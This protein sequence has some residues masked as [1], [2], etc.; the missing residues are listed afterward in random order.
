MSWG[1]VALHGKLQQ[2]AVGQSAGIALGHAELNLQRAAL[3]QHRHGRLCGGK[4]THA[5]LA[6]TYHTREWSTQFRLCYLGL[7][8]VYLGTQGREVGFCLLEGLLTHRLLFQQSLGTEHTVL[9]Q[10]QLSLLPAQFCLQGSIVYL[11]QQLTLFHHGTLL[12]EDVRYLARGL[13]RQAHLLV[14][15]QRAAHCQSIGYHLLAYHHGPH[16]QSLA[17]LLTLLGRSLIQVAVFLGHEGI[18]CQSGT[19]H[20]NDAYYAEFRNFVHCNRGPS[21]LPLPAWRGV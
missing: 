18:V 4:G 11:G 2:G 14:R 3:G 13:E 19:P 7:H 5:H 16:V 10:S 17:L 9:H 21:P 20:H 15:H 6:Q 12:E 1:Q 8:P